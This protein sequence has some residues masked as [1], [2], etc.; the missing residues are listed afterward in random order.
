MAGKSKGKRPAPEKAPQRKPATV[1]VRREL[2]ERGERRE[3][4][5]RDAN[6]GTK[7]EP[8]SGE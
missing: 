8:D 2:T 1:P 5:G 3:Q 6:E 4:D 7:T